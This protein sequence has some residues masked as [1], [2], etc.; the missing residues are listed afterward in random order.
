MHRVRI[1]HISPL[2]SIDLKDQLL[3]AGLVIDQDF[4]WE[5]RQATYNNDGYTAV[6]PKQAIFSFCEPS[7]ATFYQLKWIN[8]NNQTKI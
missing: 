4:T 1:E 3:A 6:D 5:Y 2:A 7:L 8:H